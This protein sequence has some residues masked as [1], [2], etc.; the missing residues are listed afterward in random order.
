MHQFGKSSPELQ[1][2][3]SDP[4]AAKDLFIPTYL[5]TAA[6]KA[7][8][9]AG[10][11]AKTLRELKS[12]SREIAPRAGLIHQ[13]LATGASKVKEHVGRLASESKRIGGLRFHEGR[14]KAKQFAQDKPF[15][16]MAGVATLALG[17]GFAL[18]L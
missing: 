11:A 14:Q 6:Q 18:R 16:F 2:I 10:R 8:F 5:N 3:D 9:A 7:G 12:K 15:H 1:H 4:V 13:R 17:V